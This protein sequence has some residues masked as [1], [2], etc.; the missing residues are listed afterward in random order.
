[1]A[2]RPANEARREADLDFERLY[3]GHRSDVFRAALREL[4]N[5][6]DA[7]DVT[8]AA[9][10]DAYRAVLRGSRP[11][12]P[13]A[14]L[15]AIAENVRRRR[16]RT[17]RRR[18]REEPLDPEAASGAEPSIGQANALRNAL[19]ALPSQQRDVFL[20]RE[21]AG[22]SYDEIADD[23]GSTVGAVQMLLF[24]AR[25][26]LR[27]EL[28]P[29][30]VRSSRGVVVPLPGWLTGLAARS[31]S[32]VLTP[33]AAGALGAA[34]IAVTGVG[35]VHAT[36][37]PDRP[38]PSPTRA[39]RGNVLMQSAPEAHAAAV[40]VVRPRLE[41]A[42]RRAP[43]RPASTVR[44]HRAP[45]AHRKVAAPVSAPLPTTPAFAQ[46]SQ[47]RRAPRTLPSRR[48]LP[49]AR[50]AEVVEAVGAPATTA[51]SHLAQPL[52]EIRPLEQAGAAAVVGADGPPLPELPLDTLPPVP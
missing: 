49:A 30:A 36:A 13:R 42:A 51:I 25:Q 21:I 37:P 45:V 14:W 43:S 19:A 48:Q 15:L 52:Q 16:F 24:R 12:A 44:G 11:E 39:V 46:P 3:A 41:V 26:T 27:A 40:V 9:F 23:L 33:R 8:Q 20:L 32:L 18:P 2:P 47:P 1:M 4:G 22:L 38:D 34:V 5:V 35:A 10:V 17:A 29:P 31:D 28:E 50:L 6:H 7:E